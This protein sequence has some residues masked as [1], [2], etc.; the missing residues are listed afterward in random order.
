MVAA[1]AALSLT[2]QGEVTYEL[3]CVGTRTDGTASKY[4]VSNN[5]LGAGVKMTYDETQKGYVCELKEINASTS[6]FKIVSDDQER[7][8]QVKT[9]GLTS[10][11]IWHTQWGI[12]H[13]G[14]ILDP[15]E[16]GEPTTVVDFYDSVTSEGWTPGDMSFTGG[17]AKLSDVKVVFWPDSKLLKI[18]GTPTTYKTFQLFL[19]EVDENGIISKNEWKANFKANENIKGVYTLEYDFGQED[20]VKYFDIRSTSSMPVYGFAKTGTIQPTIEEAPA[21]R[22]ANVITSSLTAYSNS[23]LDHRSSMSASA[24]K[25]VFMARPMSV[26]LKGKYNIKMDTNTG[27]VEFTAA[28]GVGTNV[29]ELIG[30]DENAP[31]EYYNMQGVRIDKPENGIYVCRQGSKV[32]KV[33]V[34]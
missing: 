1:I 7:L 14:G 20:G 4:T 19:D 3:I 34:K 16:E 31:V 12:P 6:G 21:V 17:V 26:N 10:A 29:V 9:A 23:K 28:P 24:K 15:T 30:A 22:S 13:T 25:G 5:K 8:N 18:V 2:A 11:N 32:K 27:N 33:V